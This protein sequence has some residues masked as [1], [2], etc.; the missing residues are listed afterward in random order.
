MSLQGIQYRQVIGGD[1]SDRTGDL[2]FSVKSGRLHGIGLIVDAAFIEIAVRD[3]FAAPVTDCDHT[4]RGDL[5]TAVLGSKAGIHDR[6]FLFVMNMGRKIAVACQQFVQ[7][8]IFAAVL[9][10]QIKGNIL[11]QCRN[12]GFCLVTD[13]IK[14]VFTDID[15]CGRRRK[16]T[17]QKIDKDGDRNGHNRQQQAVRTFL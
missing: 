1:I 10:N 4:V 9:C 5:V 2:T 17:C 16:L 3:D 13:R 11:V 8:R 6:V 14:F 15:L 12:N 7:G